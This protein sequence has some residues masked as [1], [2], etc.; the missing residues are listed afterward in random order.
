MWINSR[1]FGYIQDVYELSV[2][3]AGLKA[4]HSPRVGNVYERLKAR[5]HLSVGSAPLCLYPHNP[6]H[7][8]QHVK[9]QIEKVPII[10]MYFDRCGLDD[11]D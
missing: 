2:R 3:F 4:T 8:R 6:L 10:D 9:R 1:P 7:F 11:N 5:T